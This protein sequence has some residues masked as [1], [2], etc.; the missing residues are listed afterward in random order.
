MQW[1]RLL[2]L[3]SGEWPCE[4]IFW[5]G[6]WRTFKCHSKTDV[7]SDEW[8]NDKCKWRYKNHIRK[9]LRRNDGF[10]LQNQLLKVLSKPNGPK[11]TNKMYA[12]CGP[13]AWDTLFS[14]YYE[15]VFSYDKTSTINRLTS[16]RESDTRST[17]FI[18][19]LGFIS[20]NIEKSHKSS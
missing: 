18:T 11:T 10:N 19:P 15:T 20:G 6:T 2:R 16:T 12:D 13:A 3:D 1:R 4:V 5:N 9:I 17:H 14:N 8:I 7:F